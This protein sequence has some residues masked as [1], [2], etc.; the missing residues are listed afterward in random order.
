MP[1][2]LYNPIITDK[3]RF[4]E[5]D[6]TKEYKLDPKYRGFYEIRISN[7]KGF[8]SSDFAAQKPRYNLKGKFKIELFKGGNKILEK[9]VSEW[10]TAS[11]KGNDLETYEDLS[12][13]EFPIP[14]KG[15]KISDIKLKF[16]VVEPSPILKIYENDIELQVRV[17]SNK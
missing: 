9:T 4:H 12:I 7:K 14:L 6:Y 16:S 8:N 1:N 2:D 17:S 10:K 11:F 13:Y 3:F 5:P 15:F